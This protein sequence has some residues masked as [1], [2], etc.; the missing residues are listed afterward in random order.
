MTNAQ[1]KQLF[2][3]KPDRPKK[4]QLYCYLPTSLCDEVEGRAKE[5]GVR[6]F[7]LVEIALERLLGGVE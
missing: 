1:L 2:Q 7:A 3:K 5:I 4:R 6:P